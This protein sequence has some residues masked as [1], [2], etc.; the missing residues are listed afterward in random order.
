M[1]LL[2]SLL[3]GHTFTRSHIHVVVCRNGYGLNLTRTRPRRCAH[4]VAQ[5]AHFE[6]DVKDIRNIGIIA[7]VDAG[8]TTT[9]E[10][11]LYY[12]GQTRHLGSTFIA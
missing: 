2:G 3:R 1:P 8:K 11:M 4:G 6:A 5:R 10:R 9:T 7:H 12:S